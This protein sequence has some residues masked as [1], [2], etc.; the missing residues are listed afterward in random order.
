MS[1]I[2]STIKRSFLLAGIVVLAH[3]CKI[4]IPPTTKYTEE[5]IYKNPA[6]M[7]LYISGMYSE[8]NTF[9]FG[10]FPIG[11]SNATDALT[12][13][14]KYT[15]TTSGNGTVN[16]LAMD[17]SRVDAAGPQ[18]NYWNTGYGRIRRLNEFL[19]GL[20][21]YAK[22][23]EAEKEQYEAEARFIRGYVYFWL[24]KLHGSVV[25]MP[26]L[27]GYSDKNNARSSEDECWKYIA[28]D[29]AYAA[30]KLPVTQPAARSGRAT[31]G[32]AYGM[33]A[34]TWLYAASIAEY[35]KKLYNDDP[36]TGVPAANAPAYYK[37]AADAA[38]E[39]IKLADQGVYALEPN[40]AS[41]FLRK[42]TKEAIFKLD[43]IA[44]QFTHQFDLGFAPAGDI[45]GQGLLYGVP[46]AE[47]V[48]EFEMKDG[49][50]FSWSN[51]T[52]AANPYVD[53]EPRFYTTILYNGAPWKSRNINSQAGSGVDNFMD[54]SL[55]PD[56]KRTITGYYIKK[57][58]DSSNLNFVM[59]KST[60]SSIEMRYAEVL[61]IAAEARTKLNDL[62]GAAD[63]LNALR[64]KRLLPN[65]TAGDAAQFMTA[66][67][68]ERKVELAFEGH[69]YW[70]LRRWRKAHI[71]LNGMKFT[72]H[73]ITPQGAGWKYEVVPVDNTNRQFTTK[74]YYIPIPVDEI[75]RNGAMSQIKGW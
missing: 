13:V 56:P 55:T 26:A 63:A 20:A 15:S 70:D 10:Q 23:S 47:L 75:Q 71:V 65:T 22:V 48:N 32:A 9:Q 51:A 14:M 5:A 52:Q 50:K 18:L 57:M 46:T 40:F 58:L 67:E 59:N 49:S 33:L 38:T 12:D 66:I 4:D 37:N 69:R 41:L 27:E 68:H 54:F 61:L 53:R 11:Y 73:K 17:A 60:Q 3:G 28:A 25:L 64:N 42:D 39:V 74:L 1:I 62:G 36:L 44:P 16:I 24:V 72:G 45:P 2:F 21:K 7:E 35:D 34:R 19:Y 29:F 8:F 43:Y 30:E 31:K 6:N